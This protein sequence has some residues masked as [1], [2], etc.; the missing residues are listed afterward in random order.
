MKYIN[1]PF[2]KYIKEDKVVCENGRKVFGSKQ[3][4]NKYL[5]LYCG[6]V[7]DHKLCD[8]A[9]RNYDYWRKINDESKN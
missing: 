3:E 9:Q 5:K 8:I 2:F 7:H 6:E 1:C 4:K